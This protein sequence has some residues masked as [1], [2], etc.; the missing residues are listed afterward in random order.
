MAKEADLEKK[1]QVDPSDKVREA[2]KSFHKKRKEQAGGAFVSVNSTLLI[3]LQRA[4]IAEGYLK[5]E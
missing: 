1:L 5:D 4:L 3:L 2:I